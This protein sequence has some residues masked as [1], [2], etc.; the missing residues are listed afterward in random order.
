[1]KKKRLSDVILVAL[2]AACFSLAIAWNY[3]D[4]FNFSSFILNF[5]ITFFI[6]FIIIWNFWDKILKVT[7]MNKITEIKKSEYII[8]IL[9]ILL[10]LV[11]SLI[12]AYPSIGNGDAT[13]LWNQVKENRVCNW[14]PVPYV[15]IFIGI[16]SLFSDNMFSTAIFQ[17]VFVFFST[18]YLF[19]YIRKNYLNFKEVLILLILFIFNPIYIKYSVFVSKDTIYSWC[20]LILTLNL[21]N[22][23]KSD[24]KSLNNIRSK[25]SF[26]IFSIFVLLFRHN[27]IIPFVFTFLYLFLFF[28][29]IRKFV[30]ISF[31]TILISFVIM[32]GPVYKFFDIGGTNG[33]TEAMGVLMN[34]LSYYH[35]HSDNMKDEERQ[36]LYSAVPEDIWYTNY[37]SRDFNPIKFHCYFEEICEFDKDGFER[38]SKMFIKNWVS[39]TLRNPD[40]FIRSYLNVTTPIWEIKNRMGEI[41]FLWWLEEEQPVLGK[42][43]SKLFELYYNL[44]ITGPLRYLFV[45]FGEGLF[46]II[47][48]L[49]IVIRKTK[50][51][52]R[53]LLPFV[54]VLTNALTIMLLIT[55]QEYRFVYAQGLCY[56]P[57]IL[58]GLYDISFERGRENEK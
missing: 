43:F 26:L 16:P 40:L 23:V 51:E 4:P 39:L 20:M 22:I 50:F 13:H 15:Y 7:K 27:G 3:E 41:E 33:Y 6:A 19:I 12:L 32:T 14:N 29:D 10:V 9:L 1:M 44:V 11:L 55:G 31:M 18:L 24:A 17:S 36:D 37:Y 30:L 58:Y 57:L 48:S 35:M 47:F 5:I 25:F 49:F 21:I 54:P 56:I 53:K 45:T 8:Y 34:N 42:E 28:K 46:I 2:L 52:L 38:N